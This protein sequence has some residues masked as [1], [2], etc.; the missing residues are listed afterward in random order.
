MIKEL[1][2]YSNKEQIK[3]AYGFSKQNLDALKG[4]MTEVFFKK[5]TSIYWEGDHADKLFYVFK[6]RVKLFKSAYDGRDLVLHYFT[7]G[8]LF[9]EIEF[10]GT[11]QY[12]FTAKAISDCSIGMIDQ[13]DI[14]MA[15][16]KNSGLTFEFMKWMG[17]MNQF[18]QIKL[19]DL[20]F[21]GKNGALASTLIRMINSYG[22][23]EEDGIHY[24]IELTNSDLA[25][26]IGATRE[27]VNRMLQAW[28]KEGAINYRHGTIVIK[29]LNYI[30]SICHCEGCP[31]NMCRL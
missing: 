3:N 13:K 9:G 8:D 5:G 2:A 29:D 10:F 17:S 23:V 20:L 4:M 6:G 19:R 27:T 1:A 18:T 25:Q 28:K 24:S 31:L 30:K 7:P 11:E 14:E 21:Y 22:R 26:L 12:T 16:W 15:L